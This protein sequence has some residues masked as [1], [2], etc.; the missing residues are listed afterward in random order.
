[1]SESSSSQFIM[2]IVTLVLWMCFSYGTHGCHLARETPP[3]KK[4]KTSVE[5][6]IPRDKVNTAVGFGIGTIAQLFRHFTRAKE[7]EKGEMEHPKSAQT[8][9]QT[10]LGDHSPL[11]HEHQE[12]LP[13][14]ALLH[15]Q[16]QQHHRGK[17]LRQNPH[18]QNPNERNQPKLRPDDTHSEHT[19]LEE[20]QLFQSHQ[21]QQSSEE[22]LNHGSPSTSLPHRSSVPTTAPPQEKG[23]QSQTHEEASPSQEVTDSTSEEPEEKLNVPS[24]P[25][26]RQSTPDSEAH[27]SEEDSE[28]TTKTSTSREPTVPA[29]SSWSFMDL[30]G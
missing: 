23:R 27:S 20:T 8:D 17:Q 25:Q 30:F 5:E 22:T 16:R 7:L 24:E 21:I 19:N 15:I 9:I 4:T 2:K 6:D 1:M 14:E 13:S 12:E 26:T 18:Q 11:L 10:E 28:N 29:N 3:P